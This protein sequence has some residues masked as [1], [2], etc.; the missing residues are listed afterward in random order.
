M[1]SINKSEQAEIAR[2]SGASTD[3]NGTHQAP[4]AKEPGKSESKPKQPSIFKKIWASL[5]LDL[6][7]VLLLAKGGLPPAIALGLLQVDVIANHFTTI[8]YVATLYVKLN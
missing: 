7:T 4:G 6:F 3:E 2:E 1:T 8:G 5:E